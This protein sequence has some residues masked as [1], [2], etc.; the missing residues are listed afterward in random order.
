MFYFPLPDQPN[1]QNLIKINVKH[2]IMQ[3]TYNDQFN[4]WP[5]HYHQIFIFEFSSKKVV[6]L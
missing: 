3:S 4:T 5:V 1:F 2:N 6:S